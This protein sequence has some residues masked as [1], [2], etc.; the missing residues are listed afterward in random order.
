MTRS[1][2]RRYSGARPAGNHQSIV[3]AG[4]DVIEIEIEAKI[5]SPFFAVGLVSFEIM[6]GGCHGLPCFLFGQ[7]A[8]TACP[9]INSI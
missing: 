6:N 5:V 3:V 8:S 1:F 2:K 9:T 7:T 4:V